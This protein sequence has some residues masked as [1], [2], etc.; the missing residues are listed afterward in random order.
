MN[1]VATT[2]A[3][4][5]VIAAEVSPEHRHKLVF[6]VGTMMKTISRFSSVLKF[7]KLPPP[8][9]GVPVMTL[10]RSIPLCLHSAQL[11]AVSCFQLLGD[12][13][14]KSLLLSDG[15]LRSVG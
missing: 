7:F 3:M 15:E 1:Y 10:V 14:F 13:L 4:L 12:G 8:H 2:S 6:A 5:D 11:T 9:L